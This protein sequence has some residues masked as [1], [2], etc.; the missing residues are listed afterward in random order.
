MN[1]VR[2]LYTS[3]P[4]KGFTELISP[5][6]QLKNWL[7]EN[8]RQPH[9]ASYTR[10]LNK[11]LSVALQD[12]WVICTYLTRQTDDNNRP[13]IRNHSV[14]LP[15]AEY[16]QLA[17]NFDQAILAHLEEGDERALEGG[18]L[19][20]FGYPQVA[21]NGLQK[22]D[23]EAV[24]NYFGSDLERLLASLIGGKPFSVRIRGATED[25]IDLA[26]TLLKTA[27]LGDLPV[28]Q[29][30]TFEP[31]PKTRNW[32]P[33]QVLSSLQGRTAIQFQQKSLPD[34]EAAAAA[35]RLVR[36]V[37][38]FDP[39]GVISSM[40]TARNQ[41]QV[42]RDQPPAT[43]NLPATRE[44]RRAEDAYAGGSE[45]QIYQFNRE[46]ESALNSKK[47]SLDAQQRML[48]EQE[49]ALLAR[50]KDLQLR[51][52]KELGDQQKK[53]QEL[54]QVLD[55]REERLAQ[56]EKDVSEEEAHV[57]QEGA[58]RRQWKHIEEVFSV[59]NSNNCREPEDMVLSRFFD[60]LKRQERDELQALVDGVRDFFP[61]LEQIA[62]HN[63]SR[64]ETFLKDLEDIKRKLEGKNSMWRRS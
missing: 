41:A 48:N 24:A 43:I 47:E 10:T 49:Q 1:P 3:Q 58:R 35:K 45:T 18:Q 7:R 20:S 37:A 32:Y 4:G 13:F 44:V 59:L 54:A 64:K 26:T 12:G 21:K 27:A 2:F 17:T 28:P 9:S 63:D 8:L 50:E 23:M 56:R 61:G 22:E 52:E 30:A 15:E 19:K 51:V 5:E 60:Q 36:S 46:Y 40:A 42:V 38:N 6:L 53:L 55:E 57:K 62:Q 29:I 33:S 25:A 11:G 16:N 31:S 34:K 14:L 39:D